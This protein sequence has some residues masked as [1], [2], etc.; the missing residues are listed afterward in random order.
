MEEEFG[1]L[2][3][4]L[5]RAGFNEQIACIHIV[6]DV[7]NLKCHFFTSSYSRYL[8]FGMP[9]ET[10]FLDLASFNKAMVHW[11][12]STDPYQCFPC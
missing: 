3:D 4:A 6:E 8:Y 2:K 11:C 7:I 10:V 5:L 12:V 1:L 9:L